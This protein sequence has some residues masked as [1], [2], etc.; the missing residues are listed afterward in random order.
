MMQYE[1]WLA[2]AVSDWLRV[3]TDA[4]L[5]DF[6][7]FEGERVEFDQLEA[8]V[9]DMFRFEQA[10]ISEAIND[11]YEGSIDLPLPPVDGWD[12]FEL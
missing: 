4:G 6:H 7:T 11:S 2:D 5:T 3:V 1:T 10:S 12:E 8:M 9:D